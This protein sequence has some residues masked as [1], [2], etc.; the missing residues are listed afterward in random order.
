MAKNKFDMPRVVRLIIAFLLAVLFWYYVNGDTSNIVAENINDVPVTFINTDQ[1]AQEGLILDSSVSYYVNLQVKGVERNLS[2]INTK[3]ITAE[4]DLSDINSAGTYEIPV[5]I[6]GTANSIIISRVLPETVS[7]K[8]DKITDK[9][10]T[11]TIIPQGTP[12]DSKTVISAET[13]NTVQVS[14]PSDQL[15]KLS[16]ISGTIDVNGL[17]EDS[18][19]YVK[20]YPYDS[21]GNVLDDVTVSPDVVYAGVSLGVTKE[22]KVNA[23]KT[24]GTA[25]DGYKIT[26]ISVSPDT[27]TIAGKEDVISKIDS[28]DLDAVTVSDSSNSASFT[29]DENVILPDGV[30]LIGNDKQVAVTVNIEQI[31]E[32]K[33]TIDSITT[34]NVKSGL[35]VSRVDVSSVTIKVKGVASELSKINSRDLKATIDLNGKDAGTYSL[36]ILVSVS[37]GTIVETSPASASVTIVAE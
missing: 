5:V 11:P 4:A 26:D 1:L 7:V 20:V 21:D 34:T 2:E 6:K 17:S 8:I 33:Y 37:N 9:E 35:K 16:S 15:A 19:Q 27:K 30:T 29:V 31:I 3:E 12:K 36:P 18:F 28:L 24:N 13:K 22:V 25:A 32:K 10:W 23:P 14:G